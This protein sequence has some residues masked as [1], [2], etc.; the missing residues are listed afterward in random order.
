ME[1]GPGLGV[2]YHAGHAPGTK[3]IYSSDSTVHSV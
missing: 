1:P 2:G 3:I